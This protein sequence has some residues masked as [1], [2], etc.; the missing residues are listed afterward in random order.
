MSYCQ[1]CSFAKKTW[2]L[3]KYEDF[4][5]AHQTTPMWNIVLLSV[6]MTEAHIEIERHRQGKP[7][8]SLGDYQGSWGARTAGPID[9]PGTLAMVSLIFRISHRSC[10]LGGSGD[11]VS[12][13]DWANFPTHN[14]PNCLGQGTPII[15]RATRP[16]TGSC[17]VSEHP[18]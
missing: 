1:F 9:F 6:I 3:Y 18:S 11:L 13:Y 2:I 12:T 7:A 14:L 4:S 10:L 5:R 15:S 17:Q 16:V 8:Q